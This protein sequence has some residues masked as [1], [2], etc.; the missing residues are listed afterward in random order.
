MSER[1]L[2][3]SIVP[4]AI[5]ARGTICIVVLTSALRYHRR[6][7]LLFLGDLVGRA[8]RTAVIEALPGLR[9]D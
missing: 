4:R 2:T 8:G 6:M 9:V 7:K 5:E 3:R 1:R